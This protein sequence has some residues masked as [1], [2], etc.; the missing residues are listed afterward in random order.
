M[1]TAHQ[2]VRPE[3]AIESSTQLLVEGN[4]QRNFFEAM[5]DH[6]QLPGVQ[7]WDFGGINDLHRFLAGFAARRDFSAVRRLG[8]IRDA[9]RSADSAFRSVQ[10]SLKKVGLPVPNRPRKTT[11]GKP[12]VA[13]LLLPEGQ[14]SGMLE[15]VLCET[16]AGTPADRCIDELLVCLRTSGAKPPKHPE[17]ARARL[18]LA[19]REEPHLSVGVAAKRGYWD[20]NHRVLAGVRDFLSVLGR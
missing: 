5:R 19:T 7:I 1:A 3:A 2:R 18:W 12:A 17:K 10:S 13:V 15:T 8:V 20:L 11:P 14:Q 16:F 4:D 6:L 9:E